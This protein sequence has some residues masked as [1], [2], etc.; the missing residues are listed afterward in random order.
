MKTQRAPWN[1]TQNIVKFLESTK[2]KS[3]TILGLS[4][5]SLIVF[6]A[7]AIRPTIATIF[8]L[9]NRVKEGKAIEARMQQKIE[10]LSEL[11]MLMYEQE[12]NIDLLKENL[13]DK[14]RIDTIIANVEL[15]A[16]EYNLKVMSIKPSTNT[17][18]KTKDMF[19]QGL[20]VE[21]MEVGLFGSQF[22]LQKYIEH[23]EKLPRTVRVES[24]GYLRPSRQANDD[25]FELSANLYY[26]YTE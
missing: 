6:G 7:F 17:N 13:S 3:Y 25:D 14:P 24:V 23:F 21:S 2:N 19:E 18:D 10:N 20:L 26:F 16:K 22:D 15:I 9:Q 12:R 5:L 8:K 11:Q 4:F 1:N